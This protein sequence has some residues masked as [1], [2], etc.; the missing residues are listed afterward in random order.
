M[1][2]IIDG[3]VHL[4]IVG[5]LAVL[6]WQR[7]TKVPPDH[8]IA[9]DDAFGNLDRVYKREQPPPDVEPHDEGRPDQPGDPR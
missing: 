4:V 5:G 2:D 3:I 1:N 6:W 8:I 9:A 7:A